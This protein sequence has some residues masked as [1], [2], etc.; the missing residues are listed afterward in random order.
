MTNNNN[1]NNDNKFSFAI[2]HGRSRSGCYSDI[3]YRRHTVCGGI[4]LFIFCRCFL[5]VIVDIDLPSDVDFN[6][7]Q[8]YLE[9]EASWRWS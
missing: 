6:K 3:V 1:N 9:A 7:V 4:S 2:Y 5:R 8:E